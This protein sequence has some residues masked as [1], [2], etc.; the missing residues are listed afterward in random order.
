MSGNSK[1]SN[2]L[3]S[4]IGVSCFN[5]EL[6]CKIVYDKVHDEHFSN[7]CGLVVLFNGLLQVDV[8]SEGEGV[9]YLFFDDVD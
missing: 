1:S 5:C 2:Y 4:N 3:S 9:R 6:D 8:D 7:Q